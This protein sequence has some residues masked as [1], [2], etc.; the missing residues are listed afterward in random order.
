MKRF[1]IN[2]LKKYHWMYAIYYYLFTLLLKLLGLIIKKKDVMLIVCSGGKKYGDNIRP[3]YEHL[4]ND[5]RFSN[6]RFV[7]AFLSPEKFNLPDNERTTI[8]KIDSIAFYYNTLRARCWLTNVSVQRGLDFKRQGVFYINTWHGVPLKL[9]GL[10]I[11][12]G[13]SFRIIDGVEQF[14][15][16]CTMGTYD[17]KISKSAFGVDEQKI[18]VTGYPRNDIMFSESINAV[19]ERLQRILGL[20]FTKKIIL[21]APT[22]RDYCKD[23][24][25]NFNFNS[26]L[27]IDKFNEVLGQDYLLVVR[28]HGAIRDSG[29]Y[30][31]IDA[32]T[33]PDVEDLLRV[34]DILVTDYSGIM[35]DYAL[36]EKP[37]ICFPYDLEE[38]EEK[39]GL[40]V[41]Y[42]KFIPFPICR[43][44]DELY[45]IINNMNYIESC[46]I[47][48]NFVKTCGL[49]VKDATKNVVNAI[50]EGLNNTNRLL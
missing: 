46:N 15:L 39:R 27:S 17:V 26:R 16:I 21:Y 31:Y 37:I 30:G 28:A 47:S 34:T 33:Y 36:L 7:W 48:R 23:K 24:W 41:D 9:I 22:Y 20:D 45:T 32:T 14:D 2:T 44:E 50:Y 40:Y 3:V 13:G 1:L 6:W 18:K 29:L 49:V 42:E 12:E 10:D 8:C 19:K 38:Y 35:F 4:L 5:T 11:K 25:G 43:T